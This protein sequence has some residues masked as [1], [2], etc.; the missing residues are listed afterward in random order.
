MT[1]KG[2]IHCSLWMAVRLEMIKGLTT[3][4]LNILNLNFCEALMKVRSYEF[5]IFASTNPIWKFS[6]CVDRNAIF[7]NFQIYKEVVRTYYLLETFS[8]IWQSNTVK[9]ICGKRRKVML[10][11][12]HR[13]WWNE[14]ALVYKFWQVLPVTELCKQATKIKDP[15]PADHLGLAK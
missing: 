11:F 13:D 6:T 5:K 2:N 8:F 9:P 14:H 12:W 1:S 10:A 15:S 3:I 4:P 7:E